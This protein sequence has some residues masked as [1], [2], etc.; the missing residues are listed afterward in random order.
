MTQTSKKLTWTL[1]LL[2]LPLLALAFHFSPAL[3]TLRIV[4]GAWLFPDV[5]YGRPPRQNYSAQ[6]FTGVEYS[7]QVRARPRPLVIHTIAVDLT[8]PG[9]E[10]L[11]TPVEPGAEAKARTTTAFMREFDV[12][13][14]INGN[15]F[16]PFWARTPW[17]YYPRNG[18][19]VWVQ[20]LAISDSAPYSDALEGWP[21]L[22]ITSG[23]ILI[24]RN[25]CPPETWQALAGNH[26]LIDNGLPVEHPSPRLHPRTA[27]A[28]AA[29]GA[30]LWL[31]VVDGRQPNYSEGVTL[32]ELADILL[33]LG[34]TMALNLD[35][36]GSSTMAAATVH[37]PQLLNA[38]IH[39]N[40]A[41][42]QRPVANHL[43]I[44]ALP[45]AYARR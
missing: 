30:T 42:R 12:Q 19:P 11:V 20:G 13:V 39:T 31:V 43:G 26:L 14:A 21:A 8:A 40:I 36:G 3:K 44:F 22:C 1:T 18:D 27:V 37:G 10:F 23:N 34:A 15:F 29:D 45:E 6:L 28:S 32:A 25:G 24:D 41:M 33:E 17:D 2:L 16:E 7:R 35:G 9:I 5:E 4:Y 38:P